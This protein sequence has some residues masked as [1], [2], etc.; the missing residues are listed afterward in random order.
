MEIKSFAEA[1]KK[2]KVNPKSLDSFKKLPAEYRKY[3]EAMYKLTII[4]EA[5]NEGKKANWNDSNEYKYSPYFW[6]KADAKRPSGFGFSSS[7]YGGWDSNTSIGSRLS[8]RKK[9]DCLY[10]IKKFESLYKIIFLYIK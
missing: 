6:I 3:M 7:T 10:A 8:F 9:E 2:R 4:T 5:I 1:C